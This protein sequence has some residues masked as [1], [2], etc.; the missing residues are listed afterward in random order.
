MI[1]SLFLQLQRG[2]DSLLHPGR[3]VVCQAIHDAP[4]AWLCP[5]CTQQLLA[6]MRWHVREI[7]VEGPKQRMQV[8]STM[9]YTAEVQAVIHALKYDRH[10]SLA[11]LLGQAMAGQARRHRSELDFAC[12]VP[13]PLHRRRLAER[14]FNQS[15]RLAR[16]IWVAGFGR[17][18]LDCIQRV[19][20]TPSQATLAA[21]ERR[22]NVA[23][24][25]RLRSRYRRRVPGA[26]MLLIDDVCT[27]GST[28]RECA[29]ELYRHGCI[30][31]TSLVLA[32]A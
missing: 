21:E 30:E 22:R 8:Y 25:F 24:A 13:V 2:L 5:M 20:H 31:L 16:A 4:N 7:Q 3:C 9:Q 11:R 23:G 10:F 14:G 26:R 29:R 28:L 6:G 15:E 12:L 19:V 27:T 1:T 17:Q 18:V 32:T